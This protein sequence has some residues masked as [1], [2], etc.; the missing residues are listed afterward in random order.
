V[1]GATKQ[2][3]ERIRFKPPKEVLCASE[4]TSTAKACN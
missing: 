2:L 1:D 3:E 4:S